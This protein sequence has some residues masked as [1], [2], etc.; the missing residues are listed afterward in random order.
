VP[1]KPMLGDLELQQVQRLETEGDQLLVAHRVP[2]LEGDF[3]QGLG[4]RGARIALTGVL[5]GAESREGLKTL[6]ET[7]RASAPLPFV[8][9]IATATRVDEVLIEEMEV[10]ELAG[11]PERYE[12]AFALREYV[13]PPAEE[14]EEPPPVPVPPEPVEETGTLIVEVT[15]EG[16][17]GFD[18][19]KVTVTAEGTREDGAALSLTLT[20]RTNNFWTREAMP[21]GRYTARAV[22]TDPEEMNGSAPAAV[23]AGQTTPVTLALRRGAAIAKAFIVHFWFDKAFVEPCLR[24]VLRQV[25]RH[26]REHPDEKLIIVGHTDLVGGAGYNQSLSE[27]R[28]RAVFAMLTFG[29]AQAAAL[30][31]WD[32][33]RQPAAGAL[34]TV[35]D[36][37]GAREYQYVLLD[38]GYYSGNVHG[39]HDAETDAAV[40]TFQKDRGLSPVDGIVGNDTWR[41]LIEAYLGQDALAVPESQFLPNCP[42]EVLKWLG[43]GEQDP[44][45]NTQDA[46]RPNRRTELLFVRASALPCQVPEPDTFNLPAPGAVAGGWCLGPGDKADRACFLSRGTQ[47]PNTFLVQP[48]EPGSVTVQGSIRFED[49]T[50]LADSPYVLIAPD[51]ENMDGEGN[52]A[53]NRGRPIPGRTDADGNFAYPEKPKGIGIYSLEIEGP[54]LARLAGEPPEAAK[55]PVVCKRLQG[56]VAFDVIV[57][58]RPGDPSAAGSFAVGEDDYDPQTEGTHTIPPIPDVSN[59]AFTMDLR[60]LI[61]YPAQRAGR[62]TPVATQQA[63]YPLVVI[64]H[65]NHR[66]A[67]P[68]GTPVRSFEGFEYLARHLASHGYVAIS[69]DANDI[70][71]AGLEAVHRGEAVLRHIQVMA[72][73]NASDPV[74]AGKIDLTRIALVGHSRGGEGVVSAQDVNV[75]QSRG[76]D[77]RAVLS[78]APTDELHLAHSTTPYV[79]IVG[80]ADADVRPQS[81]AQLYDHAAPE[82]SMLYVYGAIHNFFNTHPDW[83][84]PGGTEFGERDIARKDA[85]V[86]AA[87][88]HLN[89][90]KGYALGFFERILRGQNAHT[91]L[92]NRYGRPGS[93]ATVEIHHQFQDP[94]RLN[95][96][97]FEQDPLHIPRFGRTADPENTLGLPIERTGLAN[98][99]EWIQS[100]HGTHAAFIRWDGPG[101]ECRT[102]LNPP[103]GSTPFDASSFRVLAFRVTL[104]FETFKTPPETIA[105]WLNRANQPQD[106]FVSLIDRQGASA[107][108]RVGTV[109]TIPYTYV[110]HEELATGELGQSTDDNLVFKTIRLPLDLFRHQNAALN[111]AD[112][113]S[114]VFEFRQTTSGDVAVDTIEFS[115]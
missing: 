79:V 53:P 80:S 56:T 103:S 47:A 46:W 115:Q 13:P 111:L 33:L 34:P 30:A 93:L 54:F 23:R 104:N 85:R 86:I 99:E 32:L 59:R 69:F 78:I 62:R 102:L 68:N 14:T 110:H 1:V 57:V 25:A 44:V 88:H 6:R 2:G 96:D 20:D 76:H 82:K 73:R 12:Y 63:S 24:P 74:L 45:L 7:F 61:R 11:K 58:R 71:R 43:H 81:A 89:A 84:R 52:V 75:R 10:R 95:V 28:A 15:V 51:G 92:F 100:T 94:R 22:V 48:A 67:L 50:P 27:R 49:G 3:L 9:D 39:R 37:W 70:N 35:K 112:L 19:G 105:G 114:I 55:G 8:S 42:N 72:G 21:P 113:Q 97:D 66:A 109:T 26:A 31:E 90:A 17:P 91:F 41:A 83:V 87:S 77:I 38:L 60:A 40:R 64:A 107:A 101:G 65:G 106:F 18:F 16:E 29:R 36:T 4:R 98:Y 5:T 108:V